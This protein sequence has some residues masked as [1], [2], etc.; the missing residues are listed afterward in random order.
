MWAYIFFNSPFP[1]DSI[2]T[3][4]KGRTHQ[5]SQRINSAPLVTLRMGSH[6]AP[7]RTGTPGPLPS[8]SSLNKAPEK[9][10]SSRR[11]APL[12]GLV[13][14]DLLTELG[15]SELSRLGSPTVRPSGTARGGQAGDDNHDHKLLTRPGLVPH[16][17]SS[18]K[19]G[20]ASVPFDR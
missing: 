15:I 12:A 19:Q 20:W 7:R 17:C 13:V 9:P 2:Q 1:S 10:I 11:E 8:S 16:S 5:N 3:K 18:G 4:N 14:C 6:R